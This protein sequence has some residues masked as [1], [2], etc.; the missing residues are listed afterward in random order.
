MAV[1]ELTAADIP[2]SHSVQPDLSASLPAPPPTF[3][4]NWRLI[5]DVEA[6][7]QP[8]PA[9]I[10]EGVLQKDSRACIYAPA[11]A[12]K[13]TLLAGLLVAITNGKAW[14]GNAI[15]TSGACLYVP[16]EDASG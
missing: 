3:P 8:K 15:T 4:E 10:V 11:N 6:Q 2:W 13:T 5:D 16:S 12:G 1:D 14:F 9:W 7:S